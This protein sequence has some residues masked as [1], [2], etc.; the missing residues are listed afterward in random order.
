MVLDGRYKSTKQIFWTTA[1]C[2]AVFGLV[3]LV[4][5]AVGAGVGATVMQ[6]GYSFLIG[7]MCA[8]VLLKTANIW[9]CVLLHTVFDVGGTILYLGGG[10]RWD[11]ATVVI[12]AVLAVIV[13]VFMLIS[14]LRIKPEEVAR[15]FP[16]RSKP[17]EQTEITE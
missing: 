15:L 8:I 4:N 7:G 1:A 17:E 10:K 3:H 11:T 14:L 5:L 13:T 12:T 16:E 9:Y 2:C 6:V